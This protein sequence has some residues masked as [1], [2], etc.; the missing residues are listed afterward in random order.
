MKSL[1][2]VALPL[3]D[4]PHSS[5][6]VQEDWPRQ[7]GGE[8]PLLRHVHGRYTAGTR[9]EHMPSL[10]IVGIYALLVLN[11]VLSVILVREG[12]VRIL[13]AIQ[14]LDENLA[15]VIAN[16][17]QQIPINAENINPIQ[18]AVAQWIGA[19]AQARSDTIEAQV[20]P[21]KGED[22]RFLKRQ[23]NL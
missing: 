12:A 18:M 21:V 7:G 20:I 19:Q 2:A 9:S 5:E 17:S 13:L 16:V 4:G 6:T 3:G 11:L 22:G 23:D 15:Q 14:E 1:P 8:P 10:E